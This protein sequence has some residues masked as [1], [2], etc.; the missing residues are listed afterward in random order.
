MHTYNAEKRRY[1]MCKLYHLTPSMSRFKWLTMFEE[2]AEQHGRD[3][4]QKTHQDDK[5][6]QDGALAATEETVVHC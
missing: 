2:A 3:T 4:R 6:G 5:D 1:V